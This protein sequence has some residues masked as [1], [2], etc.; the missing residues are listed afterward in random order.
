MKN[1]S[2]ITVLI[3]FSAVLF[4]YCGKQEQESAGI[5]RIPVKTEI[6]KKIDYTPEINTSGKVYSNSEIKL[7]FKTGGVIKKIYVED[8]TSVKAGQVLAAL[9]L[10]E[11]D[12]QVTQA[13][14]AYD[15][16]SR[17]SEIVQVLQH[18]L[19]KDFSLFQNLSMLYRNHL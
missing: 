3:I 9:D 10:S 17:D 13:K 7:S 18:C 15:K 19:R 14:D 5:K 12:A 6:I 16:A 11:I 1:K 4:T 2:T 8:G